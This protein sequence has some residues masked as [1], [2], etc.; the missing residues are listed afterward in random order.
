VFRPAVPDRAASLR[1]I[2]AFPQVILPMSV[3]SDAGS[4]QA[5]HPVKFGPAHDRRRPARVRSA[6]GQASARIAAGPSWWKAKAIPPRRRGA[7]AAER[8]P[9][10]TCRGLAIL[11][12]VVVRDVAT[13]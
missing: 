3:C 5:P 10:S 7:A 4:S 12:L 6:G 9:S 1:E 2:G 11:G 8:T 13:Q